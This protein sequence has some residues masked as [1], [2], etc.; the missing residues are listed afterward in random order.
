MDLVKASN[1]AGP[2]GD[3]AI[4]GVTLSGMDQV[5]ANVSTT[6]VAYEEVEET[7][8][9]FGTLEMAEPG[10]ALISARFNGRIERLHVDAV[11]RRVR[12]GDPLFDIYSPDIVQAGN[13]YLQ[14]LKSG[15]QSGTNT[16]TIHAKLTLLGLT[17]GQIRAIE[18]EGSVPLVAT[19]LSPVSGT[20]IEKRIVSGSYVSE[21]APLYEIADLTMLWNVAEV[22]ESDARNV[23][24]GDKV[25]LTTAAYP[26]TVFRGTVALL[27]PVV[28]PE[29]RTIRVRV[30]VANPSGKL[31]PNMYTETVFRGAMARVLTVPASAV[32]VTGK[33][34][35]VYVKVGLT[36]SFQAREV[37]LGGKYDGKYRIISGVSEGEEIV[38]EGGYLLDS[39]SQ[40]KTGGGSGHQHGGTSGTVP[41]MEEPAQHKH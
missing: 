36:N 32:L 16:S 21:G 11:G 4:A 37:L 34:N 27:Y 13:E 25:T 20:V 22:F 41:A 31:K 26:N 8:R 23:S 3:A 24:V 1:S 38:R 30:V 40:L 14:A 6:T 28:N 7:G 17:D 18:S 29:T 9:S 10:K 12:A 5:L 2:E 33:R 19:Y 39:E 15:S 35:L